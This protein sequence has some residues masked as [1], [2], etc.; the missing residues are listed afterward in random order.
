MDPQRHGNGAHAVPK[1][2]HILNLNR[3]D[4]RDVTNEF[5]GISSGTTKTR[6]VT[7]RSFGVAVTARVPRKA[8]LNV[9]ARGER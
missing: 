3:V 8:V 2:D 7:A 9:R 4:V 1:D 5:I 6:G